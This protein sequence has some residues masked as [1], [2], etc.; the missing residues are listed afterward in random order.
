MRAERAGRCERDL[1]VVAGASLGRRECDHRCMQ[2]LYFTSS[3][4]HKVAVNVETEMEQAFLTNRWCWQP[5]V[6]AMSAASVGSM[7]TGAMASSTLPRRCV[8]APVHIEKIS[9]T[10]SDFSAVKWS[11]HVHGIAHI[12]QIVPHAAVS[13]PSNTKSRML[14]DEET[15]RNNDR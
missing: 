7:S 1:T 9:R 11:D 2:D 8:S 6:S 13:V 12:R 15:R 10:A 4:A 5:A 3:T 14:Y